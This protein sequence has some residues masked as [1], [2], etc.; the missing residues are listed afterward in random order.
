MAHL[1][2]LPDASKEYHLIGPGSEQK[3]MDTLNYWTDKD[4]VRGV[5]TL[6]YTPTGQA[7]CLVRVNPKRSTNF[8]S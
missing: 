2:E 8:S 6:N 5:V 3:V 1:N 7:F 4:I